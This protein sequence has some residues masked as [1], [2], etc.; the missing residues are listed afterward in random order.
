MISKVI[1]DENKQT[2]FIISYLTNHISDPFESLVM[3]MLSQLLLDDPRGAL[4]KSLISSG[5][6]RDF[7]D[8]NGYQTDYSETH[9]TI[10]VSGILKNETTKIEEVIKKTLLDVSKKG[11]PK[12]DIEALLNRIELNFKSVK[13]KNSFS[14]I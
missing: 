10:G 8:Y 6:A 11:F 2:K 1:S 14:E 3:S 5:I 9:F 13:R 7:F 4:Y 12:K